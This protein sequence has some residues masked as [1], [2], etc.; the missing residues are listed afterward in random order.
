MGLVRFRDDRCGSGWIVGRVT[1]RVERDDGG[2]VLIAPERAS[3]L[4]ERVWVRLDATE[5]HMPAD[6][7]TRMR[8]RL[9]NG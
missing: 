3:G 9:P 8:D 4:V 5:P 1:K 6:F 7:G 2:W